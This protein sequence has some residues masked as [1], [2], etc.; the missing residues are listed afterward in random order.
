MH[1]LIWFPPG[2]Q[3]V[4][5]YEHVSLYPLCWFPPTHGAGHGW[6][7]GQHLRCSSTILSSSRAQLFPDPT[8]T[9]TA[10]WR[11]MG[12]LQSAW[13]ASVW[14][15]ETSYKDM[16]KVSQYCDWFRKRSFQVCLVPQI[17]ILVITWGGIPML[18]PHWDNLFLSSLQSPLRLECG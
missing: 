8:A 3:G 16:I 18:V 14:F 1:G 15:P 9:C 5:R 17:A 12:H 7:M 13:S 10:L 6:C 2:V 4:H 11:P